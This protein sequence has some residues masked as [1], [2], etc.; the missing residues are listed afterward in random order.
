MER[1]GGARG[2]S[3]YLV[4]VNG[5]PHIFAFAGT[6]PILHCTHPCPG[7]QVHHAIRG[8]K[9]SPVQILQALVYPKW[10]SVMQ[11]PTPEALRPAPSLSKHPALSSQP[12]R[13]VLLGHIQ[14]PM[15]KSDGRKGGLVGGFDVRLAVLCDSLGEFI[16][17]RLPF[18]LCSAGVQKT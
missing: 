3:K 15:P 10:P 6:A 11:R 14:C 9:G 13:C 1:W 4:G 2:A 5:W 7:Q 8:L 17:C 12:S 18:Q 16:V